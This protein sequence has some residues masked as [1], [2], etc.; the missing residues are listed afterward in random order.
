VKF[1]VEVEHIIYEILFEWQQLNLCQ[2]P[3]VWNM[4]LY[5]TNLMWNNVY[6]SNKFYAKMKYNNSNSSNDEMYAIR[7]QALRVLL[8]ISCLMLYYIFGSVI[9]SI[10]YSQQLNLQLRF[11]TAFCILIC[12]FSWEDSDFLGYKHELLWELSKVNALSFS[13]TN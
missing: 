2:K 6:I 8:G 9:C 11:L 13:C 4:R 1:D 7:K 5:Q 3:T 10:R 12:T